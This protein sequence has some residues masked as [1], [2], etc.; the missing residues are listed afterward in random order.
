VVADHI[1]YTDIRRFSWLPWPRAR[2]FYVKR[3]TFCASV[4]DTIK[5]MTEEFD[6]KDAIVTIEHADGSPCEEAM[7][8]V[9]S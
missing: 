2:G 4:A 7:Q 5:Y 6:M 8:Y 3:A 9:V 1:V